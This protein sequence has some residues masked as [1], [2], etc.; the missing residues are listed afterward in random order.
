M[1]TYELPGFLEK[2][3]IVLNGY[4]AGSFTKNTQRFPGRIAVVTNPPC[5]NNDDFHSADLLKVKYGTEKVVHSVWPVDFLAEQKKAN[6]IIEE[7]GSDRETRILIIHQTMAGTNAVVSRIKETRKDLFVIYCSNHEPTVESSKCANL[8][9]KYNSV[10][11]GSAIVKQAKKQGAKVFVYYSFPRHMVAKPWNKRYDIIR[12]VCE[13]EGILFVEAEVPD[14]VGEAGIFSAQKFILE[15]VPR[16]AARYGEDT[17]FFSSSCQTQAAL[18][19]AV[20]NC[21]AIYPQSCCP[22]PFHGFPEALGIETDCCHADLKH[23]IDEACRIAAEKGMTDRLSTWPVSSSMLF[24]NTGAEYAIQWLREEVSKK[25][26]D[27]RVLEECIYDYI[28]EVVGEGVKVEMDSY[29]ENGV[30]YGNYK[31]LL[32][33]YLDF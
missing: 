23:V 12:D 14:P 28:R 2:R 29:S 30:T 16:L 6:D 25:I 7:L 11:M 17:A 19:K 13:A 26:I 33:S 22:S 15:D 3:I 4:P 21:H 18:I 10:G 8:I 24:T 5:I 9:F 1:D 31:M 20:V 32:M 27:D